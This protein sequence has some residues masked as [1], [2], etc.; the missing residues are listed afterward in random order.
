MN[1][2]ALQFMYKG[3]VEIEE[4]QLAS[5]LKS[6]ASLQIQGLSGIASSEIN[7][8]LQGMKE[9]QPDES[10]QEPPSKKTKKQAPKSSFSSNS[11][12]RTRKMSSRKSNQQ[13]SNQ[14]KKWRNN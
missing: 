9:A 4:N 11:S 12:V 1:F 13:D 10:S 5:L 3:Q 8:N 14:S 7:P 2:L 6:A